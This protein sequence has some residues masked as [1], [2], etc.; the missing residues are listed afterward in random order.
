MKKKFITSL[1][2]IAILGLSTG[3]A[4]KTPSVANQPAENSKIEENEALSETE[5][6][7]DLNKDKEKGKVDLSAIETGQL[8]AGVATHDPALIQ[9]DGTYYIFGTHMATAKSEDT[10]H[11]EYIGNGYKPS[12]PVYQDLWAS[13]SHV[14]DYAG[15]GNSV[16]PTDDKQNHVWAP[17]VIYNRKMECYVLYYCTSS[18]WNASNLCYA[19]SN[20]VEGPYVW[21][22][23]LIYS[24]FTADNMDAT[25]VLETVPKQDAL[26]K[27]IKPSGEYNYDDYPNAI[28]PHPFYDQDGRMW[29]VYGSWSGG[30][31]LIELDE[32]TGKVIHPDEDPENNV[33]AYFGKRLLG[34]G[35]KS[36]EGPYIL[37]DETSG[38]Y[39][40]FVSYGELRRAGGY[41]IRVFRSDKVDGEYVDMNGEKPGKYD[42]HEK[43]GIKLSGNYSLPSLPQ[44]YMATG[45]N[46][47]I[48][49][50]EQKY[51][52]CYHTRF[53]NGG[54]S[55]EPRVKQFF[56]N[57]E[58]WPCLLP[59][60]Y[61]SE[62][63][64]ETGYSQEDMIGVYYIVNPSILIDDEVDALRCMELKADGSIDGENLDGSWNYE[65]G[66]AYMNLTFNDTKKKSH[67]YSGVFCKQKD[68][69]GTEVMTFTAV[70]NNRSVWGVKYQ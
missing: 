2:I 33:D 37:Y 54:E 13:D 24:G 34:G 22:G 39:Y 28:D 8:T 27:Y 26:A 12:N 66:T 25:D 68:E 40:L 9:V 42:I 60:S 14:F 20:S 21:Q 45:H 31:F 4:S 32:N 5:E 19:T 63:I 65:K 61:Q 16:I 67:T 7:T 43:Y 50:E 51:L 18:T 58:G 36:I 15:N 56:M 38:Y 49:N 3:C 69:A 55:F 17:D 44:A 46:S 52:I 6:M 62:T 48:I 10:I 11:W 57:R 35:H 29:L 47:A 59:Y 70:G 23:A 53:E 41:Q 1:I 30:I 64:S